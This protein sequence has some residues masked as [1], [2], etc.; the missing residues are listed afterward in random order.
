[1]R[2]CPVPRAMLAR[3]VD[4]RSKAE[5]PHNA[6]SLDRGRGERMPAASSRLH[7]RASASQSLSSHHGFDREPAARLAAIAAA[8][9]QMLASSSVSF[10]R[11]SLRGQ[12]AQGVK[13]LSAP[14][15]ALQ[16]PRIGMTAVRLLGQRLLCLPK[17]DQRGP[18]FRF[19]LKE[20]AKRSTDDQIHML[21]EF[22]ARSAIA[23]MVRCD[24]ASKRGRATT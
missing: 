3:L 1:M 20:C 4:D 17:T 22:L 16:G 10:T 7:S 21:P 8:S 2:T 18:A 11:Q 24:G 14:K 23:E 15:V 9:S 19:N 13:W 5:A 6:A 12:C